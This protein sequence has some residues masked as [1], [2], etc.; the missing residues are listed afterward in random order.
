M[1][2]QQHPRG[3]KSLGTVFITAFSSHEKAAAGL[4]SP[5][6]LW[7]KPSEVTKTSFLQFEKCCLAADVSVQNR[8]NLSY[9]NQ[10]QTWYET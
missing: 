7:R 8:V 5:T 9:K 2:V 3:R 4:S 10:L 1:G 6:V